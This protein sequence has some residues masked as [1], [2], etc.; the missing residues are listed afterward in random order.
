[1][2]RP[3][4][5]DH[6]PTTQPVKGLTPGPWLVQSGQRCFM[7]QIGTAGGDFLAD[8]Q[9]VPTL[10]PS[11]T[12]DRHGSW[13]GRLHRATVAEIMRQKGIGEAKASN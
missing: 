3:A 9:A 8:N 5:T 12:P 1:M 11:R 13:A 4:R 2:D 10:I 7:R 6:R